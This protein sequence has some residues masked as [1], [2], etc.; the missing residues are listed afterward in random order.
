MR[1]E[2]SE[3][4]G[5]RRLPKWL[6]RS[7]IQNDRGLMIRDLI[8]NNGLH[9]VCASAVCPNRAECWNSGTAAFMILGNVCTRACG[10]CGVRKGNAAGLDHEEPERVARVVSKL[11]L[12]HA[13]ITSVTRDDVPDGG[14]S[15]FADTIKAIKANSPRCKVEVLI[16]DFQGSQQSL[17]VVLDAA[18]DT[19]NHNLETIPTLYPI[20]RPKADYQRSLELLDRARKRGLTTK[21]GIMLGFGEDRDKIRAVFQDVHE[22]GCSILTIGQYLR[23]GRAQLPVQKYYHPDEFAALQEEARFIGIPNVI[24]GPHVRSS[25]HADVHMINN[26]HA[27]HDGSIDYAAS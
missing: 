10:F 3:G 8:R 27:T 2:S 7:Q 9:T 17:N 26:N 18:P 20:V 4:Q 6:K 13:V 22:A 23:P 16:P 21:T 24:S 1:V 5:M 15:L 11:G 25:Y 12:L 14:A 19:L